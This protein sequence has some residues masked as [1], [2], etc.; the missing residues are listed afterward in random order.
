MGSRK[1]KHNEKVKKEGEEGGG[2][3]GRGE[4]CWQLLEAGGGVMRE[5]WDRVWERGVGRESWG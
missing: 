4:R 3:R 1:P 5:S 2:G